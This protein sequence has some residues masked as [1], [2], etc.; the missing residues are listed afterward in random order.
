[1]LPQR[2]RQPKQKSGDKGA[3]KVC[4]SKE[5]AVCISRVWHVLRQEEAGDAGEVGSDSV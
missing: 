2:A 1:M 4:L 5:F 3:C